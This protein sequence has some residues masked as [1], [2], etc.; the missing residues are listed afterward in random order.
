M[1]LTLVSLLQTRRPLPLLGLASKAALNSCMFHNSCV[2]SLLTESYQ[3]RYH[4]SS[5]PGDSCIF[6]RKKVSKSSQRR[7]HCLPGWSQDIR[8]RVRLDATASRGNGFLYA[9]HDRPALWKGRLAYSLPS[10]E[11]IGYVDEQSREGSIC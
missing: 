3:L 5:L 11:G 9:V 1:R 10:G 2:K 7:R 4:Y 6:R 8:A